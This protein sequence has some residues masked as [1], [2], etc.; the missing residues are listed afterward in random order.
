[1]R[2]ITYLGLFVILMIGMLGYALPVS[3]A[4]LSSTQNYTVWVGAEDVGKGVSIATFFPQEVSIHV[5]DSITWMADTHEIHT[6]T[7]LA[8]EPMPELLIP[9]PANDLNTPLQINPSVG[10]ETPNAGTYDGSTYMNSGII[11]TDPNMVH[12][13]SLTFTQQGSF[14]YV[15]VVHGVIM[16]GTIN[17]V[18]D[19]V[20]VKSPEEVQLQAQAEQKAAWRQVPRVFAKANSLNVPPTKNS[21]G[22]FTRTILVGY[23]SGP[24]MIMGFFPNHMTVFP[25]DTVIWKLSSENMAPHTITFYNGTPDQSLA[26]FEPPPAGP[27]L[28]INPAVLFHS[29][30]V[31]EGTPLNTTEYFNSG[32]LMPGGEEMFSLKIGDISGLMNYECILH[33]TSGMTA[34]LFV[35]HRMGLH[36]IDR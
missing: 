23:E 18:G 29:E 6:V 17:V 12:A 28:L 33:D 36:S 15:C 25:G 31:V 26:I 16:S 22:T 20:A 13:F 8:G 32:I 27:V 19:D 4:T 3:A 34:S 2:K 14:P 10:F 7:F 5:G 30:A 35:V 11:S 21:D 1:M 9:A 24:I